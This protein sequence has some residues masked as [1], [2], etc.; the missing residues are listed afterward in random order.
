MYCCITGYINKPFSRQERE[1]FDAY[2]AHLA[3]V[4]QLLVY[5]LGGTKREVI[6]VAPYHGRSLGGLACNARIDIV[7][8]A[9][10]VAALD[11]LDLRG[12]HELT[13]DRLDSFRR[14][15]LNVIGKFQD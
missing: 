2:P 6:L 4:I 12:T 15:L 7:Q 14:Q 1:K 5:Q 3:D 9:D 11:D 13:V 10:A 8:C